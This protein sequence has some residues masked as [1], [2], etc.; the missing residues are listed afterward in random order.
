MTTTRR[1]AA[2]LAAD[3]AGYSA[4]MEKDEEGLCGLSA[5]IGIAVLW[6]A[7]A[8]RVDHLRQKS[9]KRAGDNSV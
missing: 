8:G 4:V 7:S 2:I 3:V 1:L 6:M 9:L 5:M